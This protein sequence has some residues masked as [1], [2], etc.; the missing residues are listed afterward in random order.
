[1]GVGGV[2]GPSAAQP[3]SAAAKPPQG[4]VKIGNTGVWSSQYANN[5][6][7]F[8]CWIAGNKTADQ[9]QTKLSGDQEGKQF[10]VVRDSVSHTKAGTT[11][12]IAMANPFK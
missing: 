8:D 4:Y 2:G 7:N 1:M 12:E 5:K 3:M 11:F 6:N 10:K 9:I